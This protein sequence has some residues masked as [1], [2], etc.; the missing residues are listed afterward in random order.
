[1][2]SFEKV[3]TYLLVTHNSQMINFQHL[4]RAWDLEWRDSKKLMDFTGRL[5]NT[6]REAAVHIKSKFKKHNT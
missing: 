6:I 1:M 3:K 5:E 2:S 4:I